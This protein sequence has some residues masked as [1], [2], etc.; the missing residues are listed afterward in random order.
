MVCPRDVM[1]KA[2][3][4]RIVVS[5]FGLVTIHLLA[6]Y[7]YRNLLNHTWSSDYLGVSLIFGQGYYTF[8]YKN[9]KHNIHNQEG[10][11]KENKQ[12]RT[13]VGSK[14]KTEKFVTLLCSFLCLCGLS[15]A[16]IRAKFLHS[17]QEHWLILSRRPI[18]PLIPQPLAPAF[19]SWLSS[20][21]HC[22]LL[23]CYE[24]FPSLVLFRSRRISRMHAICVG[25]GPKKTKGSSD[26]HTAT[27]TP[28]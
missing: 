26:W 23:F 11:R 17:H 4:S 24:T 5:E 10:W 2:M 1:V 19:F 22:F 15:R 9:T 21:V 20:S 18:W 27:A 25:F 12:T 28:T 6:D 13:W 8:L 14:R 7:H 16:C 3:D